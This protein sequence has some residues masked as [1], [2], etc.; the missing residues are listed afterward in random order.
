M[1]C[2][3]VKSVR[4]ALSDS[5]YRPHYR[6]LISLGLPIVIGQLSIILVAFMDNIMVGH[7]GNDEL[8]AASFVNN[9]LN[10]FVVMGL[11]FSYGL[12]PMVAEAQH[13]GDCQRLAALLKGSF[14]V[15]ILVGVFF[16]AIALLLIP[17]LG[18]FNLPSSL[19]PIVMPY[20]YL[21]IVSF[22]V[23]MLF[24]S[25]KQFFDGMSETRWPM[26]VALLG[27]V[28]N[29]I[30]NAF[31]IYGWGCFPE[32]GL[33]G[34]GVA[35]LLG[36]LSM[37]VLLWIIFC[38]KRSMKA[39][40]RLYGSIKVDK[41][42]YRRLFSLGTPISLQLGLETASF[43]FAVIAVG[44]LGSTALAAHQVATT[45]T[46]LGFMVYY[47]LGAATAIH[48]SHHRSAHD[49]EG[50]RMAMRAAIRIGLLIASGVA[51]FILCTRSWLGCLFTSD[52]EIIAY[53]ALALLPVVLYQFGDVLQIL[54]ANAL[55]GMEYV[56]T[57]IPIAVL[58]HLVLAPLLIWLFAFVIVRNNPMEQLAA[59]WSAFPITLTLMGLLLRYS[60][61][62]LDALRKA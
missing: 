62:R 35:T 43:T 26:Y 51:I 1:Y 58:C 36:R 13:R 39:I 59:V 27:N 48:I 46:T 57:L 25:L 14:R 41:H 33:F 47:G 4:I 34:A 49:Y 30:F 45:V 12:T 29:I 38:R 22:F 3:K 55:R 61:Y 20:Y 9:F 5:R 15:N 52:K 53:T 56:R 7:H 54:F 8:A 6:A 23:S 42:I 16:S 40:L 21:Q 50:V 31:L 37:F 2:G 32:W 44:K 60:F 19:L 18:W 10:L 11:G 28:L 17:Y 24:N